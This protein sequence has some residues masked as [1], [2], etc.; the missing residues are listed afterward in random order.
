[1]AYDPATGR[2]DG[3]GEH[4]ALDGEYCLTSPTGTLTCR[5]VFDHYA[6]LCR[7]YSPEMVAATCWIPAAQLEE[8]AR[9]IWHARP[10]SYYAWSGHE[11][12]ANTTET[13]RAMALLYAL[14]GS[15]D[16]AGGNVL[17][18]AIFSVLIIGEDLFVAKHLA[19]TI[20]I[21]NQPLGPAQ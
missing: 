4:L 19:P 14:T 8:T 12:H 1:M 3:P 11:H 10:V 15:F 2:Y 5:P 9:L 17:F 20:G 16:A 6:A 13:A 7:Q 21:M 18:F